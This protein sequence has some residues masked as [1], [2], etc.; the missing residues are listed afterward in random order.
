MKIT[1]TGLG[2]R[3]NQEW[4]FPDLNGEI[5]SGDRWII[6]GRNGSGK[7]T[8]LQVI[9]GILEASAGSVSYQLNDQPVDVQHLFHYLSL[10]APYQELI[11]EFTLQEMLTFH[12]SCKKPARHISM[13]EIR[14]LL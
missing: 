7:S 3:Y 2:K 10:V 5:A 9:A 12:F 14:E 1:L 13:E 8:L 4:I 6:T 11:E